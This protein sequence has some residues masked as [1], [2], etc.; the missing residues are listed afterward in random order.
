MALH[1]SIAEDFSSTPTGKLNEY[2]TRSG[3]VFRQYT[4]YPILCEAMKNKQRLHINFVGIDGMTSSFLEE[5]FG[6]LVREHNLTPDEVLQTIEFLPQKSHFDFSIKIAKEH[7]QEASPKIHDENQSSFFENIMRLVSCSWRIITSLVRKE[8]NTPMA[9][10]INV[11]EDFSPLPGNRI[12]GE[13]FRENLLYPKIC[14]AMEKNVFLEVDFT[15]MCGLSSAFL[16]EAFG[17]LVSEKRLNPR[18][19]LH[20]LK[21]LPEKSHFDVFIELTKGHINNAQLVK[22]EAK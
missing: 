1:L 8:R 15:G 5:A 12:D 9:L 16:K 7:V 17:G 18:E 19:V 20:T 13:T 22:S 3:E 10:N 21:F 6:G 4:L 2:S 14:H 11:A